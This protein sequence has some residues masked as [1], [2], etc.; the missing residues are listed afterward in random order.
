ML[1]TSDNNRAFSLLEGYRPRYSG[2][3]IFLP[4]T[5]VQEV[6]AINRMLMHNSV[7]V[8]LLQ[9]CRQDLEQIFI[10]LTTSPS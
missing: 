1:S 9:H 3:S 6:A 2:E 4:F 5:S 7:D 8:Y 10:D